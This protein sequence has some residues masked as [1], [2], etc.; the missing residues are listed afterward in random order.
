[1]NK[2]IE[3]KGEEHQYELSAYE[4]TKYLNKYNVKLLGLPGVLVSDIGIAP[5]EILHKG[6]VNADGSKGWTLKKVINMVGPRLLDIFKVVIFLL[7]YYGL[8]GES[9]M[10]KLKG[11][12]D[13]SLDN[14]LEVME[15]E[16][17]DN[18]DESVPNVTGP[19]AGQ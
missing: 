6:L 3:I 16:F 15:K 4:I 13:N 14:F 5:C 18:K 9:T 12:V 8:A 7:E 10:K 1:M 17:G 2:T 11:A 19:T